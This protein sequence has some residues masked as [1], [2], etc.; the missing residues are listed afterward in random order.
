MLIEEE[1]MKIK[2]IKDYSDETLKMLV[3]LKDKHGE[4]VKK[5]EKVIAD[6]YSMELEDIDK[7][8]HELCQLKHSGQQFQTLVNQFLKDN[9]K[10][11][12]HVERVGLDMSGNQ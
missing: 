8:A 9:E 4:H 6:G 1:K 3:S 12:A 2:F 10:K 11:V 7:L 5:I